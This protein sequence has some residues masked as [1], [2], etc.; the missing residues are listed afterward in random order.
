MSCPERRIVMHRRGVLRAQCSSSVSNLSIGN[1]VAQV[2]VRIRYRG[3]RLHGLDKGIEQWLNGGVACINI[4]R[5]QQQAI[6]KENNIS[7]QP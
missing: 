4:E 6:D 2:R 7:S 5:G 1:P 3:G